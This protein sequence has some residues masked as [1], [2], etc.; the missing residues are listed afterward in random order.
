M[1]SSMVMGAVL[2][3]EWVGLGLAKR[4][5]VAAGVRAYYCEMCFHG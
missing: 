4:G 5:D 2:W 1:T 3:M